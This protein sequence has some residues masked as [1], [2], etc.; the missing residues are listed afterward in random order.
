MSDGKVVWKEV[1]LVKGT[2]QGSVTPAVK[3]THGGRAMYSYTVGVV[4]EEGS[5]RPYLHLSDTHITEFISLLSRAALW[6]QENTN[7]SKPGLRVPVLAT[8]KLLSMAK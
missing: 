5:F 1:H 8:A 4:D 7:K 6:V 3:I 2:S